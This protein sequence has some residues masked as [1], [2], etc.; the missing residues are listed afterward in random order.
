M[1]KT[2]AYRR[3][4]SICLAMPFPSP[5][6][7]GRLY[8]K[9]VL[10]SIPLLGVLVF[11]PLACAKYSRIYWVIGQVCRR[12]GLAEQWR[13]SELEEVTNCPLCNGGAALLEYDL[14]PF[15]LVRCENCSLC[16]L[17]YRLPERVMRRIYEDP[18]YFSSDSPFGY[19]D[20]R[21]QEEGLKK[22]FWLLVW[23]LKRM[24]KAGGALLE[25]G[26]GPGLFLCQSR[27]YFSYQVGM[28]FSQRA[29]EDAESYADRV[30]MGGMD[31][32]DDDERFDLVVAIS[33]LEHVYEPVA[34]LREVKR[35]LKGHGS[36]LFV[37]PDMDGL[38]RRFLGRRWPSFKVP[39]HVVLY[40][41]RSLRM[42]GEL[43]GFE[44]I[45]FNFTQFAPMSLIFRSL[46]VDRFL[47]ERMKGSS[48][49]LP[50]PMTMIGV[51]YS[52]VE[53]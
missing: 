40:N 45:F 21:A 23:R 49:V 3:Y 15:T 22:S 28:D 5:P 34:F 44:A 25:I 12:L 31:A 6:M 46:G 17:S 33:L 53:P 42:L 51:L 35:H 37:T 11:L 29:L 38:W 10:F 18:S 52:K 36:V 19:W 50:I 24:G 14:S 27:P 7:V 48:L 20:Y 41:R 2:F 4:P 39:E 13:E 9:V 8:P 26:C 32:L 43:C 16:Y 47:P 30:V 1:P